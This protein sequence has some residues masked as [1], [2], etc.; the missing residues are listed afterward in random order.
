MALSPGGHGLAD[1]LAVDDAGGQALDG[2]KLG[3]LNWSLVVNGLTQRVDHAAD[4][5][6]AHGHAQDSPCPLDLVAFAKQGIVAQHHRAHLIFFQAH[7]QSSNAA[8]KS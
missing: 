7:G 6:F 3:R 8:R 4:E 2:Q 1:A 5:A